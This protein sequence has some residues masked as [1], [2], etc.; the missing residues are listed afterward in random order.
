[1][2]NRI[3]NLSAMKKTA[4]AAGII[5]ATFGLTSGA[6]LAQTNVTVFGQIALGLTKATDSATQVATTGFGSGIG[7]KGSE[8]LG[9]GLSAFFHLENR[10]DADTGK[11]GATFWDEKSVV[12]LSGGFGKVQLGRF[13]NAFDDISGMA[14]PFGD[15]VANMVHESALA[16]TKWNNAVGYYTPVMGGFSAAFN[17]ATKEDKTEVP[18]ALNLKYVNGP[19]AVALGYVKNGANAVNTTTLAGNYDFGAA[20]LYAGFTNSSNT[21]AGN[22]RN[23][24]IGVGV[25]VGAGT[26]KAAYSSYKANTDLSDRENKLAVGYWHNL[27]KRTMLYADVARTNT[28]LAGS[29]TNVSAFDIGIFHKF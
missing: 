28:K 23:A 24:Q 20:K 5:G 9:D 8:D 18:Y 21:G 27:S 22:A 17:T 7:F 10:F 25:P 11:L 13:A 15:T 26:I 3:L 14:D 12:G 6:A 2:S 4:I 29:D 16:E 19:L 1:M